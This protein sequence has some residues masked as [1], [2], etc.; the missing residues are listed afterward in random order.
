[1]STIL[2]GFY[3]V[4]LASSM[5]LGLVLIGAGVVLLFKLKNKLAGGLMVAVGGVFTTVP[6]LIAL[7]LITTARLVS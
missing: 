5:L 7:A 4:L 2:P 6:V 3:I 1:M